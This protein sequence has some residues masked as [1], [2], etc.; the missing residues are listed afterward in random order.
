MFQRIACLMAVVVLAGLAGSASADLVGA[1]S[2]DEGSG[3]VAADGSGNG[4]D[5]TIINATW[6]V[7]QLGS[8]LG[9]DGSAYV[10]V[11]AAAWA[12][13]SSQVTVAF[14]LYIPAADLVQSNGV[15]AAFSDPANN[16]AR[17]FSCHLPWG[18]NTVYYDTSGP[19]YDRTS[20]AIA[21]DEV[22]DAW[23]HWAFTKN[24]DTG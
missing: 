1:W 24:S 2:F 10:D 19:G 8:A 18:G 14:W 15:V 5:G 11:P 3:D 7:G 17:V 4:H 16:E 21:A 9:L 20:K 12:T 6:E 13:I 22:V 23:N